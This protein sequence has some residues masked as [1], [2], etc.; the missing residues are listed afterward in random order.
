MGAASFIACE[1]AAQG[2]RGGDMRMMTFLPS[3]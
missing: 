1:Q 3:R 2:S